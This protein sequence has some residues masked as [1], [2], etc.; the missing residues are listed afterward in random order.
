MRNILWIIILLLWAMESWTLISICELTPIM[1]APAF[2]TCFSHP[3]LTPINISIKPTL[4]VL[5]FLWGFKIPKAIKPNHDRLPH[6]QPNPNSHWWLVVL[7][8]LEPFQRA[9]SLAAADNSAM[10]NHLKPFNAWWI[11]V[12]YV[13]H[14]SHVGSARIVNKTIAAIASVGLLRSEV[15]LQVVISWG[16]NK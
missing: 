16:L 7:A 15:Q 1:T 5:I 11:G 13:W 2:S 14:A 8:F 3:M 6:K 10:T 9:I 4:L 12:P